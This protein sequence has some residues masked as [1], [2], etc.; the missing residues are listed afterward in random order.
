MHE[1]LLFAS[2]PSHQHHELLQQLCGLTAMQPRHCLERRLVF[3]AY[4]KPGSS[5]ATST[6][7]GSQD[8]HQSTELRHL[9]RMLN[10]NMF[11]THVVGGD[12]DHHTWR[13]E[14]RDIPEA[15]T[16]SGVTSRLMATA[17]LPRGVDV[18]TIMFAWGYR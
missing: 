1:Q 12:D 5:A 18:L 14:F 13:F 10:G 6:G 11:Y 2:V 4:R 16:R 9:T 17:S 3:K 8:L 15:A 7:G